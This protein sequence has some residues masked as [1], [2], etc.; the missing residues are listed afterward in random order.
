[1]KKIRIV[2]GDGVTIICDGV[3]TNKGRR[4]DFGNGYQERDKNKDIPDKNE[5]G[6]EKMREDIEIP[7][8][9]SSFIEPARHHLYGSDRPILIETQVKQMPSKNVRLVE[10]LTN[11]SCGCSKGGLIDKFVRDPNKTPD[12]SQ[13]PPILCV[14]CG[15]PV[16]GPSCQGC[17]LWRKK[18]KEVWF[19]TCHENG[20]NQDLLNT[21]ESSDDDT[22]VVNAPREPFVVKQDPGEN[23]SQSPPQINHNCCYECGDSL[24]G[25]FCQQCTCKSCGKGAHIG[26]NCP[27][28]APIISKPEPCNQTIDE[29]P[30]TLPSFDPTCHSEKE[31]SL[32]Y[33][34]KPNF[35][36]DSPNVFNPPPQPPIYS[37]EFCGNNACYG[38]YFRRFFRRECDLPPYDDSSK[39]HD[40]TFSNPLFD[41]NEDFTSSDESFS[42][43]GRLNMRNFKIFSN[44]LFDLDEEITSTKVDQIDDE[45]L[46]NTNSIPPGIEYFCFNAESDLLESLLHRDTSIN[47]S[48]KIDS[49]LDEFT[50]ELTLPHSIPPGIDDVNLDPEGDILFLESLLYDNSSPRP[51]EEFN[52]EN[53][54]E[55]FSPSPI[56]VEDSDSLMEEIDIFLDGDDSIPPGIESDDFDSEDDDNSTSRPE[57][58]SFHVDYPDSGDSTID[59]VEDIPVDVPNILPTHPAL[60]L[61]FDFISS[62]DLGSDL[63]VSSP[64]GDS[65]KIYDPGICIEVESTRFLSTLSPVIDTLLSFSSE[66]KDKVFNHGVLA[67]KEKSSSSLSLRGFKASKLFHQKSPMLI[68]GDNTPNLGVRHPHFYYSLDKLKYGGLGLS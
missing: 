62:N 44:T 5:H 21:S 26:Y 64:S 42:K 63:D 11:K 52:S 32:P 35:V 47:D 57:F 66:N 28:K 12:S 24:D 36:D 68:H 25:I 27:P 16:E 48:Q 13:R 23:S 46:E 29:L 43:R 53:P 50:G 38:H 45:V 30:Q 10:L 40:L 49:P 33:V 67:S 60:Q 18:L 55:S 34:S 41:I 56:P 61:D 7:T 15:N 31:N 17:A 9:L 4:Q 54:T 22:N 8:V 14:K 58:E 37:C 65:N 51:P 2:A 19:T 59:V 20:I 6:N 39:N 1:M 3:R